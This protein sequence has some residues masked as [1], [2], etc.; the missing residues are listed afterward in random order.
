[1]PQRHRGVEVE[2]YLPSFLMAELDGGERST[3]SPNCFT[4]EKSPGTH[5]IGDW[6]CS[7]AV[8]VELEKKTSHAPA[9]I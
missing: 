5:L 7:R 4:P 1:M 2:V 3:S 6:A 9:S 8:L